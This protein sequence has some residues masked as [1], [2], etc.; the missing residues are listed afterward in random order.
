MSW[1]DDIGA[2]APTIATALGGPL[3]GLA[4]Q[5]VGWIFGL[6]D[7]PTK[8]EVKSALEGSNLSGEQIV[9]LKQVEQEFKLRLKEL[10]IKESQLIYEDRSDA[11]AREVK[12]KDWTPRVLA[13]LVVGGFFGTL[14][15]LLGNE[16]PNG[17]KELVYLLLGGLSTMVANV[18][19]YY[20]GSSQGS[21]F[22]NEQLR[23]ALRER[24]K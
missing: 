17:V 1:L 10:G 7:S 9:Q 11:R 8:E 5:T 22:K 14:T 18:F 6:G 3:A 4:A 21:M 20:F 23:I 2:I 19:N 16:L 13:F 12:L 24:T 15:W